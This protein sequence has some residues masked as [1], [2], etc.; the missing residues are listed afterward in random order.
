MQAAAVGVIVAWAGWHV[1]GAL[2]PWRRRRL[3]AWLARRGE[4]WLPAAVISR[5]R[6]GMPETA[7]GCGSSCAGVAQ[8]AR[9]EQR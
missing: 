4:P 3:R 9:S 7:C 6:P 2:A 1:F 5:L 8:S